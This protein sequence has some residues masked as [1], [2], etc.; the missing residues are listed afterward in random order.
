MCDVGEFL[1]LGVNTQIVRAKQFWLSLRKTSVMNTNLASAL[2]AYAIE[3]YRIKLLQWVQHWIALN[4]SMNA[5]DLYHRHEAVLYPKTRFYGCREDNFVSE[6]H[7]IQL[8][9][10]LL[11]YV[12]LLCGI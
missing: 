12:S 7:P 2:P 5:M 10:C 9:S 6:A 4:L 8:Q 11:I 1:A 3:M